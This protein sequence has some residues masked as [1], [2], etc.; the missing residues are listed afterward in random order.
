MDRSVDGQ[1]P[2][3]FEPPDVHDPNF[4]DLTV[5]MDSDDD[6]DGAPLPNSS[7]GSSWAKTFAQMW[8]KTH[9]G[10]EEEVERYEKILERASRRETLADRAVVRGA[11]AEA[12]ATAAAAEAE[13]Q[14]EIQA[15]AA[16]EVDYQVEAIWGKKVEEGVTYYR[17]KWWGY[18]SDQNSWEPVSNLA[19]SEMLI[20]RFEEKSKSVKNPRVSITQYTQTGRSRR[21]KSRTK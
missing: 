19:G 7:D 12:V 6:N 2:L 9:D 8:A 1:E 17:V 20:A 21:K 13:I 18:S 4:I 15:A 11:E 10:G 14:A 5:D 16:A 3:L